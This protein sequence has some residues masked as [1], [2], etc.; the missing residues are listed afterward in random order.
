MERRARELK[1]QRERDRQKIVDEKIRQKFIEECDE[2]REAQA[3][4]NYLKCAEDRFLQCEE[5][6]EKQKIEEEGIFV[7][8]SLT[9]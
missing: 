5:N 8:L 3:R 9:F 7:S 4:L 6:I 1:E 2:L